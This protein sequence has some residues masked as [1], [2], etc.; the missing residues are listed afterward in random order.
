M[1][2]ETKEGVSYGKKV[3]ADGS[4]TLEYQVSRDATIESVSCRIFPGAETTLE[5]NFYVLRRDTEATDQLV[6]TVGKD[7]VAGDD[8][9][10]RWDVS[11]PVANGDTIVV[12]YNNTDT[13]NAHGFRANMDLDY[14]GGLS[15]ILEVIQ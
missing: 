7:H 6:Q 10:F 5:L 3:P 15:R 4:G 2:R 14:S 8:D 13:N 12:E 11:T 9:L 1:P